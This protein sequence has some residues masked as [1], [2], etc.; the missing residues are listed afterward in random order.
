MRTQPFLSPSATGTRDLQTVNISLRFLFRPIEEK[1]PEILNN[2]GPDYDKRILPSIGNEVLKSVVA[3]YNAEQLISQRE[4]VSMEIREV[5]SKRALEFDI[6]LDDVAITDLQFSPEF[7]R[8]IESKQVAQQQAERA[9]FVVAKREEERKATILKAQG[10]AEAAQ[11]VADAICES[12]PG[13]VA[14]R[15]IE[16][17]HHIADVLKRSPNVTFLSGNTLN[18]LNLGGGSGL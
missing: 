9:K 10:E 4:K 2:I 18:M 14:L 17:A 13:L 1:L 3:Q 7:A 6:I 8:A 15:K 11:L 16:A 5:L 12:G